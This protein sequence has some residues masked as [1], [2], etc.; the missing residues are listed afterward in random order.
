MSVAITD[1]PHCA[2]RDTVFI[3]SGEHFCP[4]CLYAWSDA[5]GLILSQDSVAEQDFL[6]ELARAFEPD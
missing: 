5:G 1:C 2:A 4:W 3:E 6:I